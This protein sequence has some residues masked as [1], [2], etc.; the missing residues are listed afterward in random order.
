MIVSNSSPINV[1]VDADLLVESDRLLSMISSYDR[2]YITV[3]YSCLERVCERNNIEVQRVIS[4]LNRIPRI[5][6]ISSEDANIYRQSLFDEIERLKFLENDDF[7]EEI[8][9]AIAQHI[10]VVVTNRYNEYDD[11]ELGIN[12]LSLKQLEARLRPKKPPRRTFLRRVK[13]LLRRVWHWIR[14]IRNPWY[15]IILAF[16]LVG[17]LIFT[18]PWMVQQVQNILDPAQPPPP[19]ATVSP[20]VDSYQNTDCVLLILDKSFK[21]SCGEQILLDIYDPKTQAIT[22]FSA[23][24]N[25]PEAV[26]KFKDIWYN[27]DK[28]IP[29]DIDPE[30]LIYLNNSLLNR[31]IQDADTIAILVPAEY[32]IDKGGDPER[33][34]AKELLRGVA[35]AQTLV[36]KSLFPNDLAEFTFSDNKLKLT[37]KKGLRVIIVDD[38]NDKE[39]ARKIAETLG[40]KKEIL[41]VIGH[42]ASELTSE[43]IQTY[44]D[45]KT[46]LISPGSTSEDLPASQYFFRTVPSAST[47]VEPIIKFISEKVEQPKVAVFYQGYFILKSAK[48]C[49][50]P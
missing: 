44:D 48:I 3:V 32:N 31:D 1:L 18:I 30:V 23:G 16:V 47:H 17:I 49:F 25:Y 36:N 7:R 43:V 2:L 50:S 26:K 41:A 34:L 6:I 21:T 15:L 11:A 4:D 8:A 45:N 19:N 28:N 38:A 24:N 10:G 9:Y 29:K 46:V 14:S 42:Y 5:N 33:S 27:Q 37:G 40:K 12:I 20:A 35:Q 13:N 39:R 22:A